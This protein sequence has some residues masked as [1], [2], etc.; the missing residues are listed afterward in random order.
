MVVFGISYT[1]YDIVSSATLM[2]TAFS[3]G[4]WK[5]LSDYGDYLITLSGDSFL[6]GECLHIFEFDKRGLQVKS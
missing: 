5:L 4:E 3:S 6:M 1:G 2:S